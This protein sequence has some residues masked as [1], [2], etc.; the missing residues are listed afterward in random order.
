MRPRPVLAEPAGSPSVTEAT[1]PPEGENA[2]V[3][4]TS[5]FGERAQL[6]RRRGPAGRRGNPRDHP[7]VVDETH[8]TSKLCSPVPH[9][10]CD[11]GAGSHSAQPYLLSKASARRRSLAG[12]AMILSCSSWPS[13]SRPV[14]DSI[15]QSRQHG[16]NHPVVVDSQ[17]VDRCLGH[18]D[19]ASQVAGDRGARHLEVGEL[20]V[21]GSQGQCGRLGQHCSHDASIE[22]EVVVLVG[23][24]PLHDLVGHLVIGELA[25]VAVADPGRQFLCRGVD[26]D[27]DRD[28]RIHRG[29]RAPS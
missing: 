28:L 25:G 14:R 22:H 15:F 20:V 6:L 4:R 1:S 21:D 12:R 19:G 3:A 16:A 23:G 9:S 17:V 5:P 26:E 13:A 8:N 10:A 2:R 29:S 11:L 24:D 18:L 7:G 27:L